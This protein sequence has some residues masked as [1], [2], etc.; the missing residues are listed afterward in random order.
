MLN[1]LL[2]REKT[3]YVSSSD[4]A[5]VIFA[6]GDKEKAFARWKRLLTVDRTLT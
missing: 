5:L 3:D 1:E 4:I 2:A 6:L